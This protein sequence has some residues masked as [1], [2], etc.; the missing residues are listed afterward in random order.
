LKKK[1]LESEEKERSR[2]EPGDPPFTQGG[3][4]PGIT[5]DIA[6]QQ[7]SRFAMIGSEAI[8]GVKKRR[9]GD[10]TYLGKE[11]AGGKGFG[12]KFDH[13]TRHQRLL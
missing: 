1:I 9:K 6:G 7:G 8:A 10:R 11:K 4:P 5:L 13:C 3:R 12:S 2:K